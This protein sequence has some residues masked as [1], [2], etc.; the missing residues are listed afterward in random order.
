[1]LL[2]VSLTGERAIYLA[3]EVDRSWTEMTGVRPPAVPNSA[4]GAIAGGSVPRFRLWKAASYAIST[5]LSFLTIRVVCMMFVEESG[6][7]SARE[8]RTRIVVK[9][10]T[11][12][13]GRLG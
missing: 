13:E 10:G 7:S 5:R 8:A 3:L 12:V 9:T 6:G 11:Y 1:V 4:G 2:L